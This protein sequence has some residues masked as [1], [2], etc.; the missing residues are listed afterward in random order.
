[1]NEITNN[2]LSGLLS[3]TKG[4][5][6]RNTVNARDLHV[7]LGSKQRFADWIRNRIEQYGFLENQDFQR[8]CYDWQGNLLNIRYHNFMTP[9]NQQVSKVEYF[10]SV[11]MAKELS[12]IENNE[13]GKKARR[14]FIECEN[15]LRSMM[16]QRLKEQQRQ[17]DEANRQIKSQQPKVV[18]AESVANSSDTISMEDLAKLITQNGYIINRNEL[19]EW[20]VRNGY[21]LRKMRHI[22]G[23]KVNDYTPSQEAARLHLFQLYAERIPNIDR[24][25]Y[26]CRITGSGQ[27]FF[28]NR[29][30]DMIN[31]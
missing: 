9:E 3:I 22:G 18:F 6:G 10:L 5:N 30:N 26:I 13:Q 11:G 16:E 23:R 1:M 17:V 25:R 7:F 8:F 28:V 21:L 14:Y 31:R 20:M 29:F 19:F 12:M 2:S 15:V 4:E 24:M 27:I